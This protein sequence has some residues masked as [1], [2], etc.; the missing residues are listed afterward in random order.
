MVHGLVVVW[1]IIL[2]ACGGNI[3]SFSIVFSI[4]FFHKFRTTCLLFICNINWNI[5]VSEVTVI[6]NFVKHP[7]SHRSIYK[8]KVSCLNITCCYMSVKVRTNENWTTISW[9][10]LWTVKLTSL[11]TTANKSQ[12]DRCLL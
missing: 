10:D 6:F 2:L 9:S 1:K 7:V 12:T 3:S 8:F 5:T 11:S 4:L